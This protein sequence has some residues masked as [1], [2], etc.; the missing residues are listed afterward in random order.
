MLP[1]SSHLSLNNEDIYL[2][3]GGP[4]AH[5]IR[6]MAISLF[7]QDNAGKRDTRHRHT[8]QRDVTSQPYSKYDY[9]VALI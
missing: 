9:N 8:Y 4:A 7:P 3:L 2:E 1:S 6:A 5:R